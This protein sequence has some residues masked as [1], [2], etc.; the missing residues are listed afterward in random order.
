MFWKGCQFF[1]FSDDGAGGGGEGKRRGKE[2]NA[3]GEFTRAPQAFHDSQ[4][5]ER[6]DGE[7]HFRRVGVAQLFDSDCDN[8]LFSS[9]S[10]QSSCTSK[11]LYG[12]RN[13]GFDLAV[14]T[15]LPRC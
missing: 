12:P 10:A 15:H 7:E 1:W 9:R 5:V 13:S 4:A 11:S 14:E 8:N 3:H 6:H 2:R